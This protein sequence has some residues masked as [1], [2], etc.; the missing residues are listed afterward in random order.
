MG[1]IRKTALWQ[2][3]KR[4]VSFVMII[5]LVLFSVPIEGLSN[6]VKAGSSQFNTNL[7]SI[8]SAWAVS[9][10]TISSGTIY[11]TG[12][13]QALLAIIINDTDLQSAIDLGTVSLS[14]VLNVNVSGLIEQDPLPDDLHTTSLKVRFGTD[15]SSAYSS[16]PAATDSKESEADESF[17]LGIS[18]SIP[19]GTRCILL[20]GDVLTYQDAG[21]GTVTTTFTSSST[22]IPDSAKPTISPSYNTNWTNEDIQVTITASDSV[23]VKGIYLGDDTLLTNENTYTYTVTDEG[24]NASSFYAVDFA[25]NV[26][27]TI[28]VNV[29]NIDKTSPN[30][31]EEPTV[32]ST[33][34]IN[35]TVTVTFPSITQ[36]A[37]ASL[38]TYEFSSDG[39]NFSLL[40][41]NVHT[42]S[43]EGEQTWTYRITDEAGNAS[44]NTVTATTRYDVTDP[45]I[46]S[47]NST[48]AG[49]ENRYSISVTDSYS[50]IASV[51]YAVGTQDSSYF[52]S[53]GTELSLPYEIVSTTAQSY[54]VYVED[55][56]GN[57]A[58]QTIA[59][60]NVLPTLGSI[61]DVTIDEDA[62][63]TIELSASDDTTALADLV[64]KAVS[65]DTLVLEDTTGYYSD[66]SLYLDINPLSN[67]NTDGSSITITVSCKDE[68][69]E[70]VSTDFQLTV[71]PVNDGPQA[72]TDSEGTE[73][74][75]EVAIDVLTNDTDVENDILT[76]Q[77]FTQGDNG[78]VTQDGNNLVYLPDLD[79]AGTDSFTYI[80]TDGDLT[81]QTTVTVTV[82]NINDAPIAN[83]DSAQTNEDTL[84]E[85]NVT[86][87]DSDADEGVDPAETLTVTIDTNNQPSL[88]T[89]NIT[90][91]VIE[92]TP[93]E[94]AHGTDTF[95]Y[96]LTDTEGLTDTATVTVTI[97]S[98]ND[99]PVISNAPE[100]LSITEDSTDN[101]FTFEVSDVETALGDLMV[102]VVTTDRTLVKNDNISVDF[103][104]T[105]GVCT[106]TFT[107]AANA[108]GSLDLKL[109]LS[110]GIVT[111]QHLIDTTIQSGNDAPTA[112]DD[113]MSDVWHV[114][115]DISKSL[116]LSVLT[117]N[118]TDIDGDTIT[119]TGVSSVSSGSFTQTSGQT[120]T[121]TP[122]GNFNGTV[123][124]TYTVSDGTA[125]DTAQV[126]F[127]VIKRDDAPILTLNSSNIYECEE[128]NF[129][130][131]LIISVSD[132]DTDLEDLIVT[133]ESVTE[134]LVSSDNIT[135]T[136]NLDGTYSISLGLT[137]HKNGTTDLTIDLSDGINTVTETVEYTVTPVQ[138]APVALDD[139]YT[140]GRAT[141][142]YIIPIANDYDYDDEE[143]DLLSSTS[144]TQPSA[145]TLTLQ[146]RGF[147][148]R[149]PTNSTGEYTFTYT[150]TDEIDEATAT[151]TL[152][153]VETGEIEGP[154]ISAI[155][156]MSVMENSSISDVSFTVEDTDG[157]DTVVAVSSNQSIIADGDLTV[158]NS[159]TNYTLGMSL[160]PDVTGTTYITITATDNNGHSSIRQFAVDVYPENE[161]P[162]ANDDTLPL[163]GEAYEDTVYS[164]TAAD[165]LAN[166]TDTENDTLS[167]IYVS[168]PSGYS[169]I[170]N[171][172][173]DY[174]LHPASN[175][176]GNITF[177]YLITDGYTTSAPAT[178]TV[179]LS[180]VNDRPDGD[181]DYYTLANEANEVLTISAP[182][183]LNNDDDAD[184]DTLYVDRIET[185]PLYGT[186]TLNTNGSFT[187]TRNQEAPGQ[188]GQDRFT[189]Y[190]TDGELVESSPTTVYIQTEYEPDFYL[191]PRWVTCYEDD[192]QFSITVTVGQTNGYTGTYEIISFDGSDL[193]TV[194]AGTVSGTSLTILY[195]P[196]DSE[197][198]SDSFTYVVEDTDNPGK[199]KTGTVYVTIIPVNDA[200]TFVVG[201]E[202]PWTENEDRSKTFNIQV[203]DEDHNVE[204]LEIEVYLT[205]QSNSNPIALDEDITLV[206]DSS[207]LS[208]A[209]VTVPFL[210]NKYGTFSVVFNVS[211]GIDSTSAVS[212]G[213]VLPV[214]DPPVTP[215]RSVTLTE[216]T[217]ISAE[218]MDYV[219]DIDT[220]SSELVL[221]I[222]SDVSNGTAA[223]SGD[224]IEY[225]PDF[226]F[227]GTDTLTYRVSSLDG[228][229]YSEGEV[230]FVVEAQNDAPYVYDIDYYVVT[231]EDTTCQVNFMSFDYEDDESTSDS[232]ETT[233][234]FTTDNPSVI[235]LSGLSLAVDSGD[236]NHK[237]L[238]LV[239]EA[240]MFGTVNMT[241]TATDSEGTETTL[242]FIVKVVSVND[243]PNAV[244][245]TAE[246]DEDSSVEIT[247]LANDTDIEDDASTIDDLELSVIEVSDC[248]NG[249]TVI[250]SQT[251]VITYIPDA[252]FNGT[253]S[254]TYTVSDSFGDTQTATVDVTINPV[255]DPPVAVDDTGDALE[256]ETITIDLLA[257]DWDIE[258]QRG[259]TTDELEIVSVSASTQGGTISFEN[260]ILTYT[261]NDDLSQNVVDTLT[262]V[263]KDSPTSTD[264]DEGTVTINVEQVNDPP[265]AENNEENVIEVGTGTWIFDEDTTGVFVVDIA[266]AETYKNQLLVSISSDGQAYVADSN[267]SIASTATYDKEITLVPYENAFGDFNITFTVSDGETETTVVFPVSILPVNDLPDLTV[268]D[269]SMQEEQSDS[270]TATA[271]DVETT[272]GN[273]IFT[274][275][276]QASNGTASID[277]TTGE[278]TYTPD[279]NFVG[280]D[281]FE[282]KVTDEDGGT[283]TETVNVTV[284]Q[285]NDAPTA[286]D[287]AYTIDESAESDFYVL[288]ND[289]DVDIAYGDTLTIVSVTQPDHGTVTIEDG[290]LNYVP[291]QY[292][293]NS[294]TF[295]YTIEDE[296]G[297]TSTAN[298]TVDFTP[299][300]NNPANGNDTYTIDEDDPLTS[301]DVLVNDDVD[302]DET[303]NATVTDELTLLSVTAN[304]PENSETCEIATVE[305]KQ[306]LSY[307]PALNFFGT[308]IVTY[309]MKDANTPDGTEYTF[310]ATITV[311]SIND[312]PTISDIPDELSGN[313]EDNNIVTSADI[314]DVETDVD[315]LVATA[316]WDNDTL[317]DSVDISTTGATRTITVVPKENMSG[318]ADITIKVTDEDGGEATDT[319]TVTYDSAN[320]TSDPTIG[321]DTATT[322]ENT[323][324]YIDVLKNDDVDTNLE[325][326]TLYLVEG[327]LSLSS[328]TDYGGTFSIVE[329]T[330]ERTLLNSDGTTTTVSVTRDVIEY[331]PNADWSET[332]SK[333]QVLSYQMYEQSDTSTIYTATDMVKITITPVNDEPTIDIDLTGFSTT[334]NPKTTGDDAVQMDEDTVGG[335]GSIDI[336]VNDEEDG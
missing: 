280:T 211:D 167:V 231:D 216:D 233:Y 243:L 273:F 242:D 218:I 18:T 116:D 164:F 200:P 236:S 209:T 32:S 8:G 249:K 104:T 287:D 105:T 120:F 232:N 168:D 259:E 310:T 329:R 162:I 27:D 265:A 151:V 12:D 204:D 187:Y 112:V 70:S 319:F 321:L 163:T 144:F 226:N 94:N 79:W 117:D 170:T 137:E 267:I 322:D 182:G 96:I 169:Y 55:A 108:H 296:S 297:V 68:N 271:T 153:V 52:V 320:D 77:S 110:D 172:G 301:F 260:G 49:G 141:I 109:L 213:E 19:S 36:P 24:D 252:N 148:Y 307:K 201:P 37:D 93:N 283:D 28:D 250:N 39:T 74:N 270:D 247:V 133:V 183:V 57:Y 335:T 127:E 174:E 33:S 119:V 286:N 89:V 67:A 71:T 220:P 78:S 50:G 42:I 156:N 230:E 181:N 48:R 239:P 87:N 34:W 41:E 102:Q 331:I 118:D 179:Y 62:D 72:N 5:S 46:E 304:T 157:V 140:V 103:N 317:I 245:D 235:P 192:A 98:E 73:Q 86:A 288:I 206:R 263:I 298:V 82:S 14:S 178:V 234:S 327:S 123:T 44:S 311:N 195:T 97:N 171:S 61:S 101:T 47:I 150:I 126:T 238:T 113:D 45:V 334:G 175:L 208:K 83:D 248:S 76:I 184:G 246:V 191:N 219:S 203:A 313:E 308:D 316:T 131:P 257:N 64:I 3:I 40:S 17:Q 256:G 107:P 207:D 143:L 25:G 326:D 139:E 165:L 309:T 6:V 2:T 291:E 90:D 149:A 186:V 92:Y 4:I 106:V 264:T 324:V 305:G 136:N 325:G 289:T 255:N 237:I 84:V 272:A 202:T 299:L 80:V 228:T 293:N 217:S 155:D 145:G 128:D 274:V 152:T 318:T 227:Y 197:Y 328:T 196:N 303:L 269:L 29:N 241:V 254:F 278:Y 100:S 122:E 99:S 56:A 81:S 159:G 161:T 130:N 125:S 225:I 59:A 60:Q 276:T 177:T 63:T 199:T 15:V 35:E 223:V 315:S 240:N 10:A 95:K 1:N 332:E 7:S 147:L 53:S 11:T 154:T 268:H 173:T 31:I 188:Y 222:S 66:G 312:L 23:G 198:G 134:T 54:T 121:Y 69:G 295:T 212:N 129:I 146:D 253:D 132:I 9:D 21:E 142:S 135:I 214:D 26:S 58:M 16:S 185:E 261:A 166:D 124:F 13:G 290:Y 22:V 281:S 138:D 180:P 258:I 275:S 244:D 65:S 189:Y 277:G 279:E 323:T 282:I 38:E 176:N 333:E 88:G 75:T 266:D 205:N 262:Y 91:N 314:S 251:S 294:V 306:V 43:Q 302:T 51:K 20:E 336:I 115:E 158:S 210:P 190:V 292:N 114:Y 300:N 85:I 215:D 284:T 224:K 193:G 330:V 285:V 229:V 221:T 194:E 30:D 111:V 160:Q